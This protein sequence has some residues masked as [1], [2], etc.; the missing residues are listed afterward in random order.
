M[1]PSWHWKSS[2]APD[3]SSHPSLKHDCSLQ[4]VTQQDRWATRAGQQAQGLL[5][6]MGDSETP[7]AYLRAVLPQKGHGH[8]PSLAC[9]PPRTRI[10][11][12]TKGLPV[13]SSWSFVLLSKR[14]LVKIVNRS[15]PFFEPLSTWLFHRLN[16]SNGEQRRN[17]FCWGRRTESQKEVWEDGV[18]VQR[19]TSDEKQ[20]RLSVTSVIQSFL[21]VNF[22]AKL[23]KTDQ[24]D[25]SQ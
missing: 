5:R 4:H 11:E 18:K 3:S 17:L 20:I 10:N 2:H 6:K 9:P 12:I 13:Q 15:P 1:P 21:K 22:I 25:L 16:S 8:S 19:K 7:E 23:C 24:K 14:L